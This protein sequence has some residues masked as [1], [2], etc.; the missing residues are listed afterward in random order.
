[1]SHT[2]ERASQHWPG[3]TGSKKIS[4]NLSCSPKRIGRMVNQGQDIAAELQARRFYL[5]KLIRM[6]LPVFVDG[7]ALD[8]AEDDLRE[9]LL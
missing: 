6:N 9:F 3:K 5:P 7:V 4:N 8:A 2:N 1:M